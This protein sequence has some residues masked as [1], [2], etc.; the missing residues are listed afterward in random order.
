[1]HANRKSSPATTTTSQIRQ[2]ADG[3]GVTQKQKPRHSQQYQLH[4]PVRPSDGSAELPPVGR[5]R[6]KLGTRD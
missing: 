2:I 3:I 1:M 4:A 6:K 5:G